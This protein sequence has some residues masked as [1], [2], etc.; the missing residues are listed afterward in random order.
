MKVQSTKPKRLGALLKGLKPILEAVCLEYAT[1]AER[2]GITPAHLS[3]L[4]NLK[5]GTGQGTI[6][7]LSRLLHCKDQDLLTEPT[8]LR[9]AQIV[10]D[11]DEAKAVKSRARASHM[12]LTKRQ[13][14]AA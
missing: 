2:L 11:Y 3:R 13:E 7:A 1:V 8:E 9:I 6:E 5:Q 10:A 14:G 12:A 4:A